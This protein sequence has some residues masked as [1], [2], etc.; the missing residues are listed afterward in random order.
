MQI[1]YEL[2]MSTLECNSYY[3]QS[4]GRENANVYNSGISRN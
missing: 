3:Y 1:Q 4:E 2:I